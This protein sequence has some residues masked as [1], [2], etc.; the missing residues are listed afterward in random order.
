MLATL[1]LVLPTVAIDTTSSDTRKTV[2]IARPV[3]P[4][5]WKPISLR[6]LGVPMFSLKF[7]C[8]IVLAGG[9]G[10][11]AFYLTGWG[12]WELTR[13]RY[14]AYGVGILIGLLVF[15][16]LLRL[17]VAR[18]LVSN[19]VDFLAGVPAVEES[20]FY[21]QADAELQSGRMDKAVWARA[22][23]AAKGKEDLR[24]AEYIKLRVR[25]LKSHQRS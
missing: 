7:L 20:G 15:G 5:S 3:N 24:R 14:A 8:S 12:V 16:I 22:L 11:A 9:L 2:R 17:P 10:F 21:E 25:Q 13:N 18:T 6:I 19:F 1:H 4:Q 23:V